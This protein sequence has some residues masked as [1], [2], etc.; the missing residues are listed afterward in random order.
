MDS[1]NFQPSTFWH[2]ALVA[3]GF[4]LA[5]SVCVMTPARTFAAAGFL[6]ELAAE[7]RRAVD[8]FFAAFL[9]TFFFATFFVLLLTDF[10]LAMESSS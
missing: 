8:R 6:D 5:S 7:G 1:P 2:H 4:A 9:A 3:D 10:R